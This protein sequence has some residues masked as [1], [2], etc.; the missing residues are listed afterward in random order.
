M[1]R[2]NK[3]QKIKELLTR[4]VDEIIDKQ[5]LEKRL[6]SG[7]KLRVKFGI[8]PTG[9]ELHLGHSVPF[10]K[11]KQFQELGHKIIFLIGD[12]TAMIGDPSGRA[13]ARK[14]LTENQIKHN[15]K[16][17][18]SQAGKIL[19]IKK[20]EIRYNS[21]WYKKKG[22]SFLFDLTS[23]FTIARVIERDDFKKRIKED[24]DISVLEIL[25]PLM[26]G[27]DSVELKADVEIG[28]RDQKFNL[29]MGRKVQKRYGQSKQDIIM[30]PLLEGTDGVRKMSKSYNNYIG[31]T[32]DPLKMYGKIMSI[33][34][35]VMWKYFR[36]LTNIS[37]EEIKDIQNKA[38]PLGILSPKDAKARLA[39]EVVTMYYSRK[40]AQEAEKEFKR[41]FKEKKLPTKIPEIKIK[42]KKLNILD[43]LVK[44]KLASS[45]AEAKRLIL[46]K[47]VKI[48][49]KV[50]KDWKAIIE[51][52]KG[53][54]VQKGKRHFA[55][56]N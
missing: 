38:F 50:Q 22:A 41:I 18:I 12:F 2:K 25:Y 17:Y 11:L 21:E 45:K 35:G 30:V 4:G 55:K 34:D 5:H 31:L 47:G 7:G 54:I 32:E 42:K 1:K 15:M 29:L 9:S 27:Y 24:V 40:A 46:Q 51:I 19:N 56:I 6:K 53:L 28:G 49:S 33:P 10:R 16:N 36:L 20:V 44:T 52:K 3:S 14:A 23:R 39:R 26:Q 48:N 8:D 13:E 43:L 37:A